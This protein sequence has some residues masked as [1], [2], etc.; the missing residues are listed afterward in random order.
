[1]STRY[2][3]R[4]FGSLSFVFLLSRERDLERD[5]DRDRFLLSLSLLIFDMLML[6]MMVDIESRDNYF[7]DCVRPCINCV[8][9]N[10]FVCFLYY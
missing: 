7:V 3:L 9:L 10:Y 4:L 2:V 5:L 6:L 8:C 1:M